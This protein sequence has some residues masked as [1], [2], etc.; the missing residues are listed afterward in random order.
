LIDVINLQRCLILRAGIAQFAKRRAT[1]WK[2]GVRFLAGSRGVSVSHSVQNGTG[3]HPVSYT[4]GSGGSVP[5]LKRPGR[6]ANHSHPSTAEV[7]NGMAVPPLPIRL[8]G[9]VLN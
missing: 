9:V 1:S 8:H 7:Q 2:A 4:I 5:G 3:A 6:E